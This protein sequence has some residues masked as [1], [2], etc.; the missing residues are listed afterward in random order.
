[1]T[2]YIHRGEDLQRE[3]TI[4]FPFYRTLLDGFPD[5]RLIFDDEL[6]QSENSVAPNHPYPT[7]TR[8]NCLL[9][10]DLRSIDRSH[11]KKRTGV[12]GQLYVD[13]HYNL[14][15]TVKPAVM[16]FSLEVNGKEMGSVSAKYD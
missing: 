12:D 4:T 10:A 14:V 16:K 8:P 5:S 9:T 15:I 6:I 11:F 7:A 2:W 3:Q 1:M 13:I